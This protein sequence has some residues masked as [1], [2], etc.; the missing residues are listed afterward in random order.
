M[1][2]A[3]EEET[4]KRKASNMY[5]S[6]LEDEV[7][8][9][10]DKRNDFK[11]GYRYKVTVN[12]KNIIYTERDYYNFKHLQGSTEYKFT[13]Q[14]VDEN[15]N[16]VGETNERTFTTRTAKSAIDVTKPPYNAI[17]DGQTDNSAIIQKAI[18]DCDEAHY[19]Y[20]PMGVYVCGA[21]NFSGTK[22]VML[23]TGAVLCSKEEAKKL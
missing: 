4:K 7:R 6:V 19:V 11:K 22:N 16:V 2:T 23:D 3:L 10:W 20:I 17:G 12:D 21:L 8:L 9:W 15:K 5:A 1:A 18:D 14:V 13:L